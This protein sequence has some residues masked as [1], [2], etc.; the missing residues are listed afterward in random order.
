MTSPELAAALEEKN[1]V[2]YADFIVPLRTHQASVH[3]LSQDGLIIIQPYSVT[4]AGFPKGDLQALARHIPR[5]KRSV[6]VHGTKLK[7][8]VESL[9]GYKLTMLTAQYVYDKPS[10]DSTVPPSWV[11]RP[12]TLRDKDLVTRHYQLVNEQVINQYIKA[13]HLTALEVEGKM[14]GFIGVH[15]GGSMGILVV[16]PEGRRKGYGEALER[17][18]IA[19]QLEKGLIPFCH[20]IDGNVKSILLQRKLG[21]VADTVPVYWA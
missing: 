8:A 19:S 21:L 12:L 2:R 18:L 6:T 20:I 14:V 5:G 17:H 11:F 1:R 15:Y 3:H 10:I 13:G 7:A 4:A 9:T 16:F